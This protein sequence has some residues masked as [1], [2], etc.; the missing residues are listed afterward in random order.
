[1]EALRRRWALRASSARRRELIARLQR[2]LD[3]PRPVDGYP[4]E[5]FVEASQLGDVTALAMISLRSAERRA[6]RV[7]Y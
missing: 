5:W 2:L 7:G 6:G 1:L 3:M 4:L